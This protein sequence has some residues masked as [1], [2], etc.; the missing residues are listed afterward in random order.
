MNKAF[1]FDMDGVLVDS[2]PCWSK[3]EIPFFEQLFGEK[4]AHAIGSAPGRGRDKVYDEAIQLGASINREE[5]NRGF[6]EVAKRVYAHSLITPGTDRLIESLTILDFKIGLVT[7]SPNSWLQ[8][9]LP[10]FPLREKFE[11]LICLSERPDLQ[12]KPAGD[13]YIAALNELKCDVQHSFILEDSNYGI[14]AGKASGAHTI[15]FRGN[16][17]PGYEQTGAD[18]Y[19]DTMDDVIKLVESLHGNQS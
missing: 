15:G 8:C 13:G 11:S 3:Y 17:L 2:E 1:I 16:L 7:Q 4:I 5:Y 12:P 9:V 14:A 10:R 6:D 19:A 18:A